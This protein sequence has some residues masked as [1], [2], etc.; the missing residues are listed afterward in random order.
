MDGERCF[1]GVGDE[2]PGQMNIYDYDEWLPEEMKNRIADG[3][4]RIMIE[5]TYGAADNVLEL[6]YDAL[7]REIKRTMRKSAKDMVQL[8]YLLRIMLE[9]KSWERYYSCFDEYLEKELQM[10]YTMATRFIKANKK[11]SVHG[12]S[13]EVDGRYGEYS[14][15]VL[16]EMLN[17]P[18]ELEEKVTPDMTVKQ[19]REI[20]KQ[21]KQKNTGHQEEEVFGKD[22]IIDGEYREIDDP[23]PQD[24][25]PEEVATSQPAKSAYGLEKMEYPE[26]S[27]LTTV[28]C[29]HKYDCYSC[30]QDCDIRQKNRYCMLASLGNPFNCTTME[31]LENLKQ[32][33]G[34]RCQFV[35]NDLAYHKPGNGEADPCCRDCKELCGYR[36][37][38]S[39]QEDA[40]QEADET[41]PD[42]IITDELRKIR[43]ILEKEKKLLDDYLKVGGLPE[44]TVFRQKIIVG[45]LAA[46]IC[47]LEDARQEEEGTDQPELPAMTNN[48]MREAFINSYEGWPL[49][50]NTKETGER[51]YRYQFQDGTS[52]IVKVYFHRCFDYK[53]EE[54]EWKDRF[55]EAWGSE[56]YYILTEGRHFKDCHSSRS[57]MVEF[58]KE[59]QRKGRQHE[60]M[61]MN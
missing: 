29:G 43:D 30:A 3:K 44:M 19:V 25:V 50:I 33:A 23:D 39:I 8:G 16:I 34:D 58:L 24:A 47:D 17:M 32:E 42:D 57:A 18:K 60:L 5:G 55:H 37:R 26:E 56:E 41:V 10:D 51:Y 9:K 14:Q 6:E 2:I 40:T 45:A 54:V 59:F 49:W 11:Y 15:A 20:K 12:D 46:M 38:R 53:S 48:S 27:L 28:G 7:N 31:V 36:C 22:E 13:T 35:N 52:F 4:E 21:E 61:Q 1:G